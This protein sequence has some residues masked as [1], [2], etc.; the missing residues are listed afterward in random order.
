MIERA[1]GAA[2]RR[3]T[4]AFAIVGADSADGGRQPIFGLNSELDRNALEKL[5]QEPPEWL[6]RDAET[7][8][9]TTRLGPSKRIRACTSRTSA[10]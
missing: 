1:L 2:V 4:L 6:K 8:A 3:G 9:D 10:S 5:A 7:A